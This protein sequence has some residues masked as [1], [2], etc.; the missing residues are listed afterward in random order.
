MPLAN[1]SVIQLAKLYWQD[2]IFGAGEL[3]D[4]ILDI[5]C[6]ERMDGV[7]T[8]A[9]LAAKRRVNV[10]KRKSD[11]ETFAFEHGRG[12]CGAWPLSRPRSVSPECQ[13]EFNSVG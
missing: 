3:R 7:Q 5:L 6:G 12:S 13:P 4:S 1:T 11:W 8:R 9:G 2:R 10:H